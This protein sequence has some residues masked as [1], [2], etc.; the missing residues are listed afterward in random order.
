MDSDMT[1][2]KIVDGK[3]LKMAQLNGGD[4]ISLVESGNIIH[5][6]LDSQ[7]VFSMIMENTNKVAGS[8]AST[9]FLLDENSDELVFCMPTGPMADKLANKRIKKGQ[10]IAGWV[11]ENAEAAIVPDV[12]NDPRFFS[13]IDDDT[14]FQTKSILC[15]PLM[16]NHKLIGV[17]EAINKQDGS[18]F[19]EKDALLLSAFAEQTVMAIENA[20]LHGALESQLKE[21]LRLKNCLTES[22]QNKALEKLSVG[23]AHDFKNILNAISGFAEIVHM[24]TKDEKTREDIGEILKAASS[25]IDL[26]EQILAFTRQSPYKKHSVNSRKCFKQAV[27]LFRIFL[28]QNIQIH[29][30]LSFDDGP[31][32]ANSTQLHHA[33][34]Q[35]FK[36]AREAIGKDS[37]IIKIDSFAV[38][39]DKIEAALHPGL[40][41]GPHIKLTV[42]DN[43]RGMEAKT[44]KQV[45]DPYF[46]TKAR[47]V[48]TGMGL[49]SVQ[50]IIQDHNGAIR[51]ASTPGKGTRVEILLPLQEAEPASRTLSLDTLPGGTEHLLVVDDEKVLARTL[52]KMLQSLGYRVTISNS[53][54]KALEIFQSNP[55]DI[56]LVLTDWA[57]PGMTGDRLAEKMMAVKK[58]AKVILFSAFDDGI[59]QK[60]FEPRC[61]RRVLKKPISMEV[62]AFTIRQVLQ[63]PNED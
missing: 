6:S 60:N 18:S 11:L 13:G 40:K 35:I 7:E 43:G 28:P 29:E 55:E 61:I 16:L 53:S 44:L 26:V 54:E 1:K 14:G 59:T 32:F 30:N 2:N 15:V 52:M 63:T 24:D 56:N 20:R 38:Q 42:S 41:P 51:I 47:S 34:T 27:K 57:M 31:L 46:T 58:D 36:N 25:A 4:L 45:F 8:E 5:S 3:R 9:L 48:G 10:G 33:I 49:S 37:G 50:G 17:I 12:N 62:L 19:T 39:V 23:I 22:Q 21:T